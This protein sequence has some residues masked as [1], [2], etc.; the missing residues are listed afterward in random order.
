M[1]RARVYARLLLNLDNLLNFYRAI[2]R[3]CLYSH[4]G[5][6]V[7]ADDALLD[8]HIVQLNDF[9]L[10]WLLWP[11]WSRK[12]RIERLKFFRCKRE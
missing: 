4:G 11:G 9:A 3:K 2:G 5:A 8:A 10:S 7:L 12:S 1:F 6:C